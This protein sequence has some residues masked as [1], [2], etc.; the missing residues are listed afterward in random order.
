[1]GARNC[2]VAT[3][4]IENWAQ[5]TKQES[6]STTGDK[7]DQKEKRVLGG[8]CSIARGGKRRKNTAAA[9]KKTRLRVQT[10]PRSEGGGG[11]TWGRKSQKLSCSD[12]QEKSVA[13][14]LPTPE[15]PRGHQN[16]GKTVGRKKPRTEAFS[17]KKHLKKK[18]IFDVAPARK[19]GEGGCF[20]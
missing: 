2:P 17:K 7:E 9:K 14:C 6:R 1:L 13:I 4:R 15:V 3:R 18:V 11:E 12:L 8:G 5:K 16:P 10:R 19:S 20:E